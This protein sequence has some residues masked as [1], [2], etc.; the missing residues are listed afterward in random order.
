MKSYETMKWNHTKVVATYDRSPRTNWTEKSIFEITKGAY[1]KKG[2]A[3]QY[4]YNMFLSIFQFPI[5]IWNQ[6]SI[7]T[8]IN[9]LAFGSWKRFQ[10]I[11]REEGTEDQG[12]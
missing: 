1:Q 5:Y 12:S 8:L 6:G 4:V 11:N 10:K 3:H 7:V 2:V 9:I